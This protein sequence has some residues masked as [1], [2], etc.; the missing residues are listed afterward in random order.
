MQQRKYK[1]IIQ[2]HSGQL[3]LIAS[4]YGMLDADASVRAL[5]DNG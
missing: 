4:V 3:Q 2:F 1:N 5:K